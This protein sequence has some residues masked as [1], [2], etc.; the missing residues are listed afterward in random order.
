MLK[1]LRWLVLLAGLVPLLWFAAS[2]AVYRIPSGP[3]QQVFRGAVRYKLL[4]FGLSNREFFENVLANRAVALDGHPDLYASLADVNQLWRESPGGMAHKS[5]AYT[6]TLTARP[7]LF[8]G[9]GRA[10]ISNVV[11]VEKPPVTGQ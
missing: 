9:Y 2:Y 8:G 7:L 4:D 6:A 1:V 3:A 11:R 10:D 5:D